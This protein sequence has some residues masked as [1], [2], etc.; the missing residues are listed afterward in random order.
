MGG[1]SQNG[2]SVKPDTTWTDAQLVTAYQDG[3]T[4][5]WE[6]LYNRHRVNLRGFFFRKG[7]VN[8]EDLN[9]LVQETQLEA[10]R[11]INQIQNPDSFNGWIAS[12]ALGTMS[13]WLQKEDR[14]RELQEKFSVRNSNTNSSG[15]HAPT[16]LGPEQSAI[17]AE[18]LK[19]IFGL[20]EQLPRSQEEALLLNYA[21]MTNREIAEHLGI[22]ANATKVRL[23]KAKKKLRE[24][25]E[26]EYPNMFADL[27]ERGII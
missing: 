6:I 4:D 15:L 13:R 18:Y 5:A 24:S 19:I 26:A 2:K 1:C 17:D 25:L 11:C 23:S 9:D 20:I 10:M 27:L 3:D 16:Y 22:S 12:I 14:R 7:I 21:G 8:P